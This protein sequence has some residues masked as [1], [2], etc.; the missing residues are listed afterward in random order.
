M[1]NYFSWLHSYRMGKTVSTW[2]QL[3]ISPCS[4]QSNLFSYSI[5]S[6]LLGSALFYSHKLFLF[7]ISHI[8]DNIVKTVIRY[9]SQLDVP[10]SGIL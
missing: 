4:Y 5:D 8:F 6:T 10:Y 9:F 3:D 7:S 1:C 2:L